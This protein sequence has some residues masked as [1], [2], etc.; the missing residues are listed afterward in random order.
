[1]EDASP[2]KRR[3]FE[4]Q[5]D[6]EELGLPPPGDD[7]LEDLQWNIRLYK[8]WRNMSQFER[9]KR[10]A[11]LYDERFHT[12]D[13]EKYIPRIQTEDQAKKYHELRKPKLYAKYGQYRGW[14]S[15]KRDLAL[16]SEP[17]SD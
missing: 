14:I 4:L 16:E 2:L 15:R 5:Q 17:A 8:G 9:A 12:D 7:V 6:G 13:L 11:E 1:M 10:T 3:T